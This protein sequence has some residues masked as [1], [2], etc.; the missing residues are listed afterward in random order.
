[1][2]EREL[3]LYKKHEYLVLIDQLVKVNGCKAHFP[4]NIICKKPIEAKIN[5]YII[6]DGHVDIY[7]NVN[8]SIFEKHIDVDNYSRRPLIA[9]DILYN[10]L[11]IKI[12]NELVICKDRNGKEYPI[13]EGLFSVLDSELSI[14]EQKKEHLLMMLMSSVLLNNPATNQAE[15]QGVLSGYELLVSYLDKLGG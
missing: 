6:D 2:D 11:A 3:E 10:L 15:E 1:M 12:D 5:T 9:L 14:E 7:Y 4:R 8:D 13:G